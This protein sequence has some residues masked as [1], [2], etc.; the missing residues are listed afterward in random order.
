[1]KV[2]AHRGASGRKPEMTM[3]AYLAAIE[4]KADGF[5]CDVRLTKD[6]QIICHHDPTTKRLSGKNLRISGTDYD[7]IRATG[8]V[9]KLAEL[10]DL[11]ILNRK[12]LLIETKHPVKSGGVIE[13]K[14]LELLAENKQEIAKA[15]ISIFLMSFSALA[16]KR[17]G[18]NAEKIKITKYLI[19]TLLS[20]TENLAI[21]LH[22]AKRYR[23]LINYLL[24]R[25]K[26]VFVWTVNEYIDLEL[27]RRA[28]V[29]AVISDF[30]A[31]AH[32]DE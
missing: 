21:D 12:N 27:C 14:V 6:L 18:K 1:M 32:A 31:R 25:R 22:L 20:P 29:S 17:I 9:L 13:G 4:D 8:E 11:A 24:G 19:S 5:E 10:L 28:K 15:E 16:V 23:G 7:E 30:P 2:Y 3:A 26:M